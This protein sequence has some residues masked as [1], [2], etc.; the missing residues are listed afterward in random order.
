MDYIVNKLII[1][2]F[3]GEVA[4]LHSIGKSRLNYLSELD[5]A[6]FLSV[7]RFACQLVC[8]EQIYFVL[9]ADTW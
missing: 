7:R 3:W 4:C 6:V 5:L 9:Y 2:L 8:L 1:C